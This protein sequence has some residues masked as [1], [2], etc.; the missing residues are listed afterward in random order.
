[1]TTSHNKGKPVKPR[2]NSRRYVRWAIRPGV[3][4]VEGVLVLT[5]GPKASASVARRIPAD[6]GEGW[7][8]AKFRKAAG[9]EATIYHVHLDRTGGR[10][11]CECQG[12]LR[13]SHCKHISGL[14][15]LTAK[16]GGSAS[17]SPALILD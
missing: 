3:Y 13:W 4:G 10:H 9:D 8:L 15:A 2:P 5:V 17:E 16:E 14:L 1:M 6:G 12:F 7:E 11:S